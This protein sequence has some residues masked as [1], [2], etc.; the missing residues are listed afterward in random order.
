MPFNL[1]RHAGV[2]GRLVPDFE[3]GKNQNNFKLMV[4]G[5]FKSV[6]DLAG[7]TLDGQGTEVW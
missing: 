3:L 7:V 1:C 2:S 4:L 6:S 5:L